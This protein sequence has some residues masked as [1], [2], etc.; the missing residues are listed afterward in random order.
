MEPNKQKLDEW[1]DQALADY[2]HA[3]HRLGLESR[4][5]ANLAE[6]KARATRRTL[7]PWAFAS[8]AVTLTV[9]V[10]FWSWLSTQKPRTPTKLANNKTVLPQKE[11]TVSTES[12]VRVSTPEPVKRGKPR[13]LAKAPESEKAPRLSQFPSVRELSTQEQLLVRY[14]REFPEQ[15]LAVAQAQAAAKRERIS[16]ELAAE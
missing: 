12:I 2:G 7:W 13:Q 16:A 6:E 4:I 11:S 14:A 10:A 8:I 9:V 5:L 3:E 1:L 15:A